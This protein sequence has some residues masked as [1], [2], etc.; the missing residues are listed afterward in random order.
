VLER[1]RRITGTREVPPTLDVIEL[2]LLTP[3]S[4]ADEAASAGFTELG[5]RTIAPTDAHV[6]S[7]VVVLC[8]ATR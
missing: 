1:A 3:A 5:T 4:L 7:D 2:A 8:A 6:G